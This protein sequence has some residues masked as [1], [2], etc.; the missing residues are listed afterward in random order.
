MLGGPDGLN[1]GFYM[2][3]DELPRLFLMS[4]PLKIQF[5]DL[6]ERLGGAIEATCHLEYAFEATRYHNA[7][8]DGNFYDSIYPQ[9]EPS[10]LYPL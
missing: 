10:I 4:D 9:N 1:K 7:I 3:M 6:R 8:S 5:Y 2:M